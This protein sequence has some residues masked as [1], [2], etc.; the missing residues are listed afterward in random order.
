MAKRVLIVDSGKEWEGGT[1]SLLLL[2]QNAPPHWSWQA[3][4]Y[5][6]YQQQGNNRLLSTGR[7][8]YRRTCTGKCRPYLPA[9][10]TKTCVLSV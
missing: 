3:A 4:F 2:V 6:N 9:D 7:R 5:H 8:M 1:N 10:C